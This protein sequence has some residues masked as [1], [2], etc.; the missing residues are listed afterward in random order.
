MVFRVKN[1]DFTPQNHIFSNFRGGAR[2]VRPPLDPPMG[3]TA[4]EGLVVVV[5]CRSLTYPHCVN[6]VLDGMIFRVA[7]Y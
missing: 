4:V 1:H 3:V 6:A 2:R 7:V 5:G